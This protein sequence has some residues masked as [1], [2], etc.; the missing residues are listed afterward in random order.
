MGGQACILYGGAEFSRDVDFAVAVSPDNLRRLQGALRAQNA[1][2]VFF[3]PLSVAALKRGHACHFR[4]G[5]PATRGL[6]VDVMGRM[7][8]APSFGRLWS[9]R[10]EVRVPGVGPVPVVSL[11]D[12]VRI[13]KTQR[14][15]DW[16]MIARLL[17]A[18]I[19]RHGWSA[20]FRRIRFWL[21]ECRT[22]P[23][24]I[25]LA[26]RFPQQARRE[27]RRR[28]AVRSA[29]RGDEEGLRKGLR[30]EQERERSRTAVTGRPSGANSS[31]CAS[32]GRASDPALGKSAAGPQPFTGAGRA[33]ACRSRARSVGD[34]R[35]VESCG[36]SHAGARDRRAREDEQCSSD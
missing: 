36:G 2:P 3:P 30:L 28:A 15:K 17:E 21:S 33:L 6:R 29:V 5:A 19:A 23:L 35:P 8:G 13:K 1:E 27:A 4:C 24:L 12:L 11:E 7:R 16:A 32:A 18:D 34:A 22:P 25:E 10:T 9:R 20:D 31:G 26:R 14:D